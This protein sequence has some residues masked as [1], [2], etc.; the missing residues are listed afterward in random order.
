MCTS[1]ETVLTSYIS[2]NG[3]IL[4]LLPSSPHLSALSIMS[5]RNV[6]STRIEIRLIIENSGC[7]TGI[8]RTVL[9]ASFA[10][11][12]IQLLVEEGKVPIF[13]LF[14][15]YVHVTNLWYLGPS[16]SIEHSVPAGGEHA[17]LPKES[18]NRECQGVHL[19]KTLDEPLLRPKQ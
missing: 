3:S 12:S 10:Q 18:Y 8:G 15:H 7:I 5:R 2:V 17:Q 16:A 9:C 1:R 14:R 6:G 4:P 11:E 19:R 13:V